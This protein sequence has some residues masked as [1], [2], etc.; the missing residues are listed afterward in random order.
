MMTW[1]R[2][3]RY[4]MRWLPRSPLFTTVATLS[5]GSREPRGVLYSSSMRTAA[6]WCCRSRCGVRRRR[7]R[8]GRR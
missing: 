2:D 7:S 5:L 4:A 8:N 1:V 3:A 6:F